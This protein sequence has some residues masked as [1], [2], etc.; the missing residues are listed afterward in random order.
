[1]LIPQAVVLLEHIPA[2]LSVLLLCLFL[3]L[4]GTAGMLCGVG[5]MKR[6]VSVCLSHLFAAAA[7]AGF[8]AVGLAG[9]RYRSIASAAGAKANAVTLT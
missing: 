9:K 1:M 3:F 2:E 7:C 6:T 8:P 4:F 5:S